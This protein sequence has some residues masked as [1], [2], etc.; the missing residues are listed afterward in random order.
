[1]PE[2]IHGNTTAEIGWTII[3]AL[4][5]VVVGRPHRRRRL[6]AQRGPAAGRA[7]GRGHRPAV[8][9]GVPLRHRRRRRSSTTSSPPTTSSSRSA[10]RSRSTITSRDVIHRFWVPRLNGKSDAVPNRDHPWKLEADEPGEYIGQ[11]TEF[12]GLSHAK[13]RIKAD[14]RSTEADFDEL[15]RAASRA[16]RRRSP[17]TTTTSQ[18][19]QGYRAVHRPAVRQLPPHRGRQRRQVRDGR[20]VD[21]HRGQIKDPE[22]QVSRG[23]PRTSPTS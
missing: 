14:R 18:A 3:P 7:A 17:R 1:M 5:L 8:V 13:M 2:Q 10:A 4:I 15:G 11:C 12:C 20:R 19:A 6:Q 16:T 23:T 21:G 9:V 22:L